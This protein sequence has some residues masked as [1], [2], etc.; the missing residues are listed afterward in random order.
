MKLNRR[1]AP[2]SLTTSTATDTS[3]VFVSVGIA[4]VIVNVPASATV[5]VPHAVVANH[6]FAVVF[7]N[8]PD[9]DI[10]AEPVDEIT[11]RPDE[12][13]TD[14]VPSAEVTVT[15][16]TPSVREIDPGLV[17]RGVFVGVGL[18]GLSFGSFG[19]S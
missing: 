18:V 16:A 6:D 5:A 9:P 8:A 4:T 13:T 19:S 14:V 1:N 2:F 10:N 17:V 15:V 12:S 11:K 3:P 7:A